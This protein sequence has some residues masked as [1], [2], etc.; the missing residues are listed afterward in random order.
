MQNKEYSDIEHIPHYDL[1]ILGAGPAGSTLARLLRK[2]YKIIVVDKKKYT[3]ISTFET[4]SANE[5]LEFQKP[6]GG[7]LA[8]DAQ[9]ALSRFNLTL[10]KTV[11]VDPQIFAVKTVDTK[12][13][14][15]RHYQRFY[16]NLDRHRFDLWLISL[17]PDTVTYLDD[18]L[19]TEIQSFDGGFELSLK[20]HRS[21]LS[22]PQKIRATWI[23][24]ADGA[25]S[26]VRRKLFP[27]RT[28]EQYASMQQWFSS[29]RHDA[30]Y[31]CVFDSDI[32]D[33]YCWTVS[34]DGYFIVGGAFPVDEA[35]L[36]FS[37][38]KDKLIT[39]HAFDY[40]SDS[41]ATPLRNEG[42]MVSFPKGVRKFCAARD[43]AFLIGEAAGFISPSSLEGISYA[44]E[45]AYRLAEVLNAR[46]SNPAKEYRVQSLPIRMKLM[47][48]YLKRPFMYRPFLRRFA[49]KSGI[50]SIK[51]R[52]S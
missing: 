44:F 2:D 19:A 14:I 43:N 28:I 15:V 20:P 29:E 6:C 9:K 1:A 12:Q 38:L 41:F 5:S 16:I 46:P 34:K 51:I 17:I 33:S 18:T 30:L 36:R 52:E 35:K 50:S 13:D 40:D 22:T 37:L 11:L 26:L 45:S 48:K 10:P 7:L 47:T 49:M 25:S 32:T 39:H 27:D 4:N 24:G 42:C 21:S 23:V 3:D 8:P 31:S